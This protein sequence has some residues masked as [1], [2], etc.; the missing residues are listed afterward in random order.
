MSADPLG[1]LLGGAIEQHFVDDEPNNA[2]QIVA[3]QTQPDFW[4]DSLL[5]TSLDEQ[6]DNIEQLLNSA[7]NLT[8]LNSVRTNYGFTGLGQT[9]AII[10]SG[11]A[12]DHY[13]LG[14]GFGSGYRVVGGYDFTEENDA[15]PY[16]DGTEG[17]HGTHV[18]G[19]VGSTGNTSGGDV[20]VAPGVD[21]VGLRVF[22]DAGAGYFHWVEKALQWVHENRNSFENPITTV[23][24]SLGTSWNSTTVPNW[25]TL[26]D[27]FAQLE[28]AGIFI[29]VSAGNS[30]TS[31]N[32][33]GLSYPA[34]SSHV[35]PVMSVDD[36]GALSYF[37]Q[38]HTSAI[39]APG[40]W[41]RST[42]P[43]YAGNH[44]GVADDWASFS[45]TSMAAPYVAGG[46][47]LVRQAMEFVGYTDITQDTIY[48][49]MMATADE[50]FDSA[51]S[52]TYRRLNLS[53]AIDALM[54]DDDFGSSVIDAFDLGTLDGNRELSGHI[55]SLNDADYFRF[56]A[57]TSGTVTLSTTTTHE[58]ATQ[59]DTGAATGVLGQGGRQ[60][61][62]DVVAGQTYT[63]GFS[64]SAGMGFYDL[65]ID[66]ESTF[67]FVDWGTVVGQT[68]RGDIE[69][70]G[71]QWYRMVAGQTGF[72]TTTADYAAGQVELSFY[73][74]NGDLLANGYDTSSGSRVDLLA[75]A[76]QEVYL[77]VVGVS[78][79]VDFVCTNAVSLANGQLT[80]I[81]TSGNDSISLVS[82]S[83][84]ELTVNG[85]SYS[86]AIAAAQSIAIDAGEGIDSIS[87]VGTA[88]NEQVTLA[89]GSLEFQSSEW[90]LSA[91][92]F[93]VVN[94]AG[95]GGVDSVTMAD[96]AGDDIF[97]ARHRYASLSGSNFGFE[98]QDFANV[99]VVASTGNDTATLHDTAGD[100]VFSS[101]HNRANL[102]GA[103][104]FHEAVGFDTVTA[105]AT[106][107]ND[108]AHMRDSSGDD[109]FSTWHNRAVMTGNGYWNDAR[110][111]DQAIGYASTGNDTAYLRDSAGD[112]AYTTWHNRAVMTG[113]GYWNDA[114]GFD[115]TFGL[116]STGKD[117]AHLRD[118]A[119]DDVY[120]SW[121]D[122]ATIVGAGFSHDARGFDSTIAYASTGN[123]TAYFYDSAGDDFFNTWHNRAMMIG[124]GYSNDA[125]GFDRA[126]AFASTGFD[127]AYLRDSAGD[128]TY[129]TWHNRAV[130]TG[131][132]FWND[133]RGFDRTFGF[134]TTG[135]D[136]AFLRDSAGDDVFSSWS[137]RAIMSGA[138]YAHDARNFRRVQAFSTTGND[139]A[140]IRDSA[141]DDVFTTWPNRAM[142]IGNN[143]E[144]DARGF[145]HV[146]GISTGGNDRAFLRDSIGNDLITGQ[147][148]TMSITGNDFVIE[149]IGFAE[150]MF[151]DDFVDDED[152]VSIDAYDAG[153]SMYRLG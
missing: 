73:A 140:T 148:A 11:I 110:G 141:G 38:R 50:F 83:A 98:V 23:N 57:A 80:V 55:A 146:T 70:S 8:G 106:A 64:S 81:G 16:D 33:P 47:V 43:D 24:L 147:G 112:D 105:F 10:D 91:T 114:R 153:F 111:F 59:W 127:T 90:Q 26:E 117:T 66:F 7:H 135:N 69:A 71:D 102:A 137:D 107:G 82:G 138:G 40:R 113:N 49:H 4:L 18:A 72:L 77:R 89:P 99:T 108:I 1:G 56:T 12:Y 37:S 119:G 88:A 13:A 63:V 34:A 31:Y 104:Y 75:T 58:L 100:D 53:A 39:A 62:L 133:A 51:T 143:F 152:E 128:D 35:V 123:D 20:G 54:P 48:D 14:G 130:M 151:Y 150:C 45:G 120:T 145:K 19:I 144:V 126:F 74:T 118:S 67:S 36:T 92:G 122:R 94:I 42:V 68:A 17:S 116:A 60:F 103:D 86:F 61:T 27:E 134:A 149:A 21:L 41:I 65:D 97:V 79:N 87:I 15:D 44:N 78:S 93:D 96:S 139:V 3:H 25:T 32:T 115:R 121:V 46:S 30:F 136:L 29:A 6:F 101:W 28:A 95:G 124:A 76:G 22:N 9:V 85:V 131:N 142:M 2:T 125:R 109:L 84:H 5:E 129:T 52:Q 132:G